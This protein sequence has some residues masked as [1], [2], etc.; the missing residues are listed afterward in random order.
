MNIKRCPWCGKILDKSKDT[1]SWSDVIG[2]P[3]VPRMLRQ[4]NCGHCAYKY[5]QT[6]IFE[7][8]TKLDEKG[9]ICAAR[10]ELFCEITILESYGKIK[11]D[12]LYFL[13]PD[14]DNFEPFFPAAPIY[15]FY[16]EKESNLAYGEFLYMNEKN[17]AYIGKESCSLYDTEM[18]LAAKIKLYEYKKQDV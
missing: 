9:K 12:N 14:F 18:N 4:A 17:Y 2:K 13:S 3:A 15:V 5:G 1:I 7:S 16:T 10:E 11:R 8:Y 6:S